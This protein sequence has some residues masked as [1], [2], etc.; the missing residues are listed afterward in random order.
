MSAPETQNI[1]IDTDRCRSCA[2][3]LEA[4]P[5][6]VF[7]LDANGKAYAAY[8]EDCHVCHQCEDDC[9]T[10]C[11]EVSHIVKN[12]RRFSIYDQPGLNLVDVDWSRQ[13]ND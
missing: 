8:P 12:T 4:C 3:C 7:R 6:D 5:V 9:P 10:Q 11:I 13:I 1:T 2:K